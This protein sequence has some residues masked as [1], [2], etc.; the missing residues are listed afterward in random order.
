[1]GTIRAEIRTDRP[2]KKGQYSIRFVI[3][4]HGKRKYLPT[5]LK[6]PFLYWDS[7]SEM[8][9]YKSVTALEK[10]AAAK[11]KEATKKGAKTDHLLFD[12]KKA[13]LQSEV[14]EITSKLT[15]IRKAIETALNDN[16]ALSIESIIE[17]VE[18]TIIPEK[19]KGEPEKYAFDYIENYIAEHEGISQRGSMVVYKSL[20]KHLQGFQKA[21]PKKNRVTWE[22]VDNKFLLS[23]QKYL[24][25][26]TKE[27]KGQI[28][29]YMNNVTVA[30]QISCLKTFLNYA[31]KEGHPVNPKFKDFTVKKDSLEVIALTN[32]EFERLYAWEFGNAK[33]NQVRDIF[34]FSCVTGFRYSDLAQFRWDHIHGDYIR[35]TMV[36][37]VNK[38]E[39][40]LNPYSLKILEKYKG[41]ERPLPMISNVKMNLYI[42]EACKIAG[43]NSP[44]EKVRY[45]GNQR[46]AIIY[47]KHE[48]TSVHSGRKTFATLSLKRGMSAEVVMAI[49]GWQD[50]KSFK[51]YVGIDDEMIRA[52][53]VRTWGEPTL[54]PKLR[55][56]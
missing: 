33:L 54:E 17:K 47:E 42:K 45:F 32:D 41:M 36:K 20:K 52:A 27:E 56:V 28:L 49:G 16:P 14:T 38:V 18:S 55:A 34:C 23:F 48:V 8:P 9:V 22:N 40:P 1:M 24:H 11:K 2:D 12:P 10:E 25:A 15:H 6:I 3:S 37:T 43:I 21:N 7:E 13:L 44:V 50:Y 19:R 39:V 26:L 35:L 29:P 31:R 4:H 30:K 51:R 46:S 5:D 53:S